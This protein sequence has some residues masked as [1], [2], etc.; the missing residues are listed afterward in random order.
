MGIKD[1]DLAM[2]A[3]LPW[4]FPRGQEND[5]GT[6]RSERVVPRPLDRLPDDLPEGVV[7][8]GEGNG[9]IDGQRLRTELIAAGLTEAQLDHLACLGGAPRSVIETLRS[10]PGAGPS[11]R[12]R[13]FGPLFATLRDG[14]ESK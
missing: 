9:P 1:E 6:N 3:S 8:I 4:L 13:F 12:A 2:R 5:T 11:P 7:D 14:G 10:V